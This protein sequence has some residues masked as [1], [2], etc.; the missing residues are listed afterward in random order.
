MIAQKNL[1][2]VAKKHLKKIIKK[3]DLKKV[4]KKNLILK[5]PIAK[6]LKKN[7]KILKNLRKRRRKNY[8]N[9][10]SSKK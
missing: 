10:N 3:K 7:K 2:K 6:I 5:I 9:M 4:K 8:L 1:K